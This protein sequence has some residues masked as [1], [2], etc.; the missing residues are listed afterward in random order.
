MKVVHILKDGSIVG[1]IT[2]HIVRV[3]DAGPLYSLISSI[4]GSEK[5]LHEKKYEVKV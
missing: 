1:D 4:N 3:E 5:K 2:G